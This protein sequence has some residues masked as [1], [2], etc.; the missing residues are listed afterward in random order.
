[1][2]PRKVGKVAKK[3][4]KKKIVEEQESENLNDDDELLNME[5]GNMPGMDQEDLTQ[6]EKDEIIYKKLT[7]LN[8]QAAIN[9]TR[10]AFCKDRGF[11]A[12]ES[13]EHLVVHYAVDGDILL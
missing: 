13:N 2:P 1:M 6:E 11:K 10:F 7:S 9:I 3:G 8:P 4:G 5:N 12:E